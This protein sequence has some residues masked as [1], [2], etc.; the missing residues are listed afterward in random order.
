MDKLINSC[1]SSQ[2]YGLLSR[3]SG[4]SSWGNEKLGSKENQESDLISLYFFP[5]Y[6]IFCNLKRSQILTQT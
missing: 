5:L 4:F 1:S 6:R 3:D 2:N